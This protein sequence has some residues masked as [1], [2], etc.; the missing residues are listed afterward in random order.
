MT[1][2][3]V[4]TATGLDVVEVLDDPPL[5]CIFDLGPD[6]GVDVFVSVD[7]GQ[8]RMAGPAAVLEAYAPLLDGGEAEVIAGLGEN[9]I[10]APGF[11]GLAVDAGDGVFI[12]VG[13]NGGFRELQEPREPLIEL[14]SAALGRI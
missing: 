1:A 5:S 7:D 3:E 10:Y 4:S 12:A 11:R 8:G 2:E 13:I 14:M 6:A 9:A